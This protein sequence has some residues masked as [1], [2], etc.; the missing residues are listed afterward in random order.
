MGVSARYSS[1]KIQIFAD[2]KKKKLF[3]L[4]NTSC[5][6]TLIGFSKYR[7]ENHV[8]NIYLSINNKTT[9]F[10]NKIWIGNVLLNKVLIRPLMKVNFYKKKKYTKLMENMLIITPSHLLNNK[11]QNPTDQVWA[12]KKNITTASL[13]NICTIWRLDVYSSVVITLLHP[14]FLRMVLNLNTISKKTQV[15]K[16]P[17]FNHTTYYNVDADFC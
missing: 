8:R 4:I 14:K 5:N 16:P 2:G 9:A 6:C 10:I 17:C 7:H 1:N 15:K 13:C 11:R 12:F 3:F